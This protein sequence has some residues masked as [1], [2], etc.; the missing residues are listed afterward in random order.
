MIP[1]MESQKL[2]GTESEPMPQVPRFVT[3]LEII[4]LS[5]LF[6]LSS[7]FLILYNFKLL[8]THNYPIFVIV[9]SQ[10]FIAM[11]SFVQSD[12]QETDF[13]STFEMALAGGCQ[14]LSLGFSNALYTRKSLYL[15][16]SMKPMTPVFMTIFILVSNTEY[17][18]ARSLICITFITL[19]S[20]L[21]SKIRDGVA[22]SDLLYALLSSFF[23]AARLI[24]MQRQLKHFDV[25][26]VSK[27]TATCTFL[28]ALFASLVTFEA[29]EISI[30]YRSMLSLLVVSGLFSV[31]VNFCTLRLVKLTSSLFLKML[32]LTKNSV[33][34]I[35]SGL[36]HVEHVTSIQYVGY[37]IST[38]FFI[39][40]I[41]TK[42]Q[43]DV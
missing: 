28:M 36:T 1:S 42:Y 7:T 43:E 38:F 40:Y 19:G 30:H 18:S 8:S 15:V 4:I 31:L 32:G 33:I 27:K 3:V 29:Y 16:Q 37:S 34:V 14:F 24:L 39:A 23:E 22:S 5:L 35:V 9:S 17:V 6:M 12:S 26:F 20:A 21:S 25:L 10:L 13:N 2:V 41:L 11:F